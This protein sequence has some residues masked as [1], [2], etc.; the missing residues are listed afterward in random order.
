VTR[1]L[2]DIDAFVDMAKKTID[3]GDSNK[4]KRDFPRQL[5]RL[6]DSKDELE[7][8]HRL[9]EE[10]REKTNARRAMMKGRAGSAEAEGGDSP[11]AR[12]LG[13]PQ[14]S[15]RTKLA[16]ISG[17]NDALF[18]KSTDSTTGSRES[19]ASNAS[20][21]IPL[22]VPVRT[23]S[24]AGR[25]G[26]SQE[27]GYSSSDAYNTL[28]IRRLERDTSVDRMSTGSRESNR[29]TQSEWVRG[30]K[31]G[32]GKKKNAGL[33]G[34]LKKLTRGMSAEREREF[35]SGSD[36]SSV[37]VASKTNSRAPP[38]PKSAQAAKKNP[39]DP[40]EQYFSKSNGK[41]TGAA[42]S[43]SASS[44]VRSRAAAA[45]AA[46]AASVPTPF[47]APAAQPQRMSDAA[48]RYS[49]N[50]TNTTYGRR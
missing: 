14:R 22:P 4:L 20:S 15:S 11:S 46:A 50:S 24:H 49:H 16:T 29:S 7:Q 42:A 12:N 5:A 40:F 47:G 19:L 36:I 25:G 31:A 26:G 1:F 44:S 2:S 18:W 8:I 23:R 28:S 38:A 34:K 27:S 43:S 9:T 37:S 3:E 13:V 30:D 17:S 48:A 33:I 39:N 45:A 21:S 41:A 10:E 6:K 35:G 32:G